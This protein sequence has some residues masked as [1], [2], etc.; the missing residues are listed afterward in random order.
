MPRLFEKEKQK[1]HLP[2]SLSGFSFWKFTPNKLANSPV[3][4]F[5]LRLQL[6]K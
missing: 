1:V 5:V 3:Q 2:L 6:A 4:I